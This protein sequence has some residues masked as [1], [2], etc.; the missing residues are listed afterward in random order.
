MG[1]MK[2]SDFGVKNKGGKKDA[3]NDHGVNKTAKN[4]L[5]RKKPTQY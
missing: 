4:L 2:D 3:P 5:S 1:K